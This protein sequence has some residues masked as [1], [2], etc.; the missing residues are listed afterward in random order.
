MPT[1]TDITAADP[2]SGTFTAGP[3]V[4]PG[5]GANLQVYQT[6]Y[7]PTAR[8]GL[9]QFD[10]KGEPL[11]KTIRTNNNCFA[12]GCLEN[13]ELQANSGLSWSW[14][15]ICFWL[16][17]DTL[18]FGNTD[19]TTS[20]VTRQASNGMNRLM[21]ID[22]STIDRVTDIVFKGTNGT[23]WF[24]HFIAKTDTNK[25]TPVY[26]R[27]KTLHSG[28]ARGFN[29]RIK[30]WHPMNKSI[31]YDDSENGDQMNPTMFSVEG[32][33]G[34]GDFYIYDIFYPST[35][36]TETDT[37]SVNMNTTYYWHER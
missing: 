23:D 29:R 9:D 1:L 4:F 19:P 15:R 17:G 8:P 18:N 35:G 13:I 5:G 26:D 37:L 34:A 7:C 21:T 31:V 28:N 2:T 30:M 25:I 20:N 33:R 3:A 14:R 10:V 22:L 32:R 6:L 36:G 11:D 27:V 16:K 24:D 12:R